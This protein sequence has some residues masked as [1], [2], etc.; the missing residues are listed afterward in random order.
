MSNLEFAYEES[1]AIPSEAAAGEAKSGH[2][3]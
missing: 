3:E 2:P 1:I